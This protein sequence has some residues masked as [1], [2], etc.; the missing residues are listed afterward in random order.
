MK[1]VDCGRELDTIIWE[2]TG[3]TTEEMFKVDEK[4]KK[5]IFLRI[6]ENDGNNDSVF[7]CPH[8]YTMNNHQ[9][10]MGYDFEGRQ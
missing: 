4:N 3:P 9:F 10:M 2:T 7:R 8:C 6:D 1:C 5:L